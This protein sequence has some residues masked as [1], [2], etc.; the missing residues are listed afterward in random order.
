MPKRKV[1]PLG[2][3]HQIDRRP[4]NRGSVDNVCNYILKHEKEDFF[5]GEERPSSKHVYFDAA[6]VIYGSGPACVL[7]HQA[8]DD[9]EK[10]NEK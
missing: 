1:D 9:W 4:T 7:L 3:N 8:Q 6:L 5:N 10:R 2:R